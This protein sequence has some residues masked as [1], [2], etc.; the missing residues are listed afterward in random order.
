[1]C[2]TR[3][4]ISALQRLRVFQGVYTQVR[5]LSLLESLSDVY[6]FNCMFCLIQNI[7]FVLFQARGRLAQYKNN[8]AGLVMTI[9]LLQ[10]ISL[11]MH[12]RAVFPHLD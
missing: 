8:A 11:A 3:A 5:L 12:H 7:N 10:S 4:K 1:M 9:S 6:E 2:S